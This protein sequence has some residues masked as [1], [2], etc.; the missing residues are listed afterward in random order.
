MSEPT[1]IDSKA[2][3]LVWSPTG[4][5]APTHR[6]PTRTSATTEAERLAKKCPGHRFFVLEAMSVAS[7]PAITQKLERD[8][9]P[10]DSDDIPF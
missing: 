5:Y 10:E 1:I 4:I 9:Q 7:V 8:P 2:F 6:H 3:W